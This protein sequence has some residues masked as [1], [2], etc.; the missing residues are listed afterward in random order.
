MAAVQE[1]AMNGDIT[2]FGIVAPDPQDGPFEPATLQDE[3]TFWL[4]FLLKFLIDFCVR[5]IVIILFAS[6]MTFALAYFCVSS[7]CLLNL[8]LILIKHSILNSD[9]F[10]VEGLYFRL[11]F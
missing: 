7:L 5:S 10:A 6:S 4:N 3:V 11:C 9:A 8:R 2:K 1:P